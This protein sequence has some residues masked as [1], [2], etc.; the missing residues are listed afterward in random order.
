M[1]PCA[2]THGV[3]LLLAS[4]IAAVVAACGARDA[5][6]G[7]SLRGPLPPPRTPD[8]WA[9]PRADAPVRAPADA[10]DFAHRIDDAETWRRLAARPENEVFART[11]VVKFLIDLAD[12]RR[13]WLVQ[14]E[15]FPIHYEFA[16]RFLS[17]PAPIESHAAF[18]VREYRRPDR[19][20]ICGTVVH[21]LDAD[22]WTFEMLAGDDLDAPRI[23]EAFAQ[24][25][26]AL[27]VGPRLRYRPLSALHEARVAEVPG[28]LEVVTTDQLLGG[29]AYQPLTTG[30][31][32]GVLR[33]VRGALDPATVG[34]QEILVTAEVPDDLPMAMGLVTARL[35]APLAHVALLSANRGTPNM[36]LRGAVDDP[37]FSALEGRVVRLH[38][39]PQDF[40]IAEAPGAEAEAAWAARRPAQTFTPTLD[41]RGRALREVC[42]V[43]R[44]QLGEVGAKAAQLGEVCRLGDALRAAGGDVRTPGG[45]VIPTTLYVDHLVRADIAPRLGAT[46]AEPA[47][48]ADRSTRDARLAA[49]RVSIAAAPVDAALLR[50][51]RARLARFP[52]GRAILRSSTNAEDLPGFNG[53]GLYESVVLATDADDAALA[54]AL[55][56]VW[57]SV[58]TLRGFEERDWFRIDP[59]SV[60]MAVLVQ[61]FVPHAVANG[62]AI[63]RNPFNEGRPAV[64]LNAQATG[65][66]VTGARDEVP[67]QHLV[68]T[69]TEQLEPERLGRSSRT[70][71]TDVLDADDVLRV[72]RVLQRLHDTLV[73]TY[74]THANAVDVEFL[75]SAPPGGRERVLYLVQARP[76]RVAYT[77]GQR[78]PRR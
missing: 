23:A 53:A 33:I 62:V 67:E 63:T 16:R 25:R 64:F 9:V 8:P 40:A 66:S 5:G 6:L 13:L 41:L 35:Q 68:Y 72:A 70:G 51:V 1:H 38:V 52:A 4:L 48:R 50:L 74:G 34:A 73:P 61:P 42:D 22:A 31:T 26:A 19:R 27:H 55:R 75:I 78:Y 7:A 76:Y 15:R 21:H 29:V 65:G 30:T 45:F 24:V 2:W 36:A 10:P 20:F 39:G 57:A 11:E 71:G 56:R 59:L 69:Y 43:G 32:Y 18:N 37:R 3:A 47:F 54:D 77:D 58:F 17:G 44:A 28:R 12:A 49:L 46:F 60:A 14:T